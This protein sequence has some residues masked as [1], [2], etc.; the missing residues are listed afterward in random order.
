MS[1]FDLRFLD[2]P[3]GIFTPFLS[4][5]TLKLT[6]L[7]KSS[8][9]YTISPLEKHLSLSCSLQSEHFKHLE[10]HDR[11]NTFNI[12]RSN[13]GSPH[14]AHLGIAAEE[15]RRNKQLLH[16]YNKSCN[17]LY[18]YIMFG[19]GICEKYQS[20]DETFPEPNGERNLVSRL[21]FFANTPPK[22]D[23]AV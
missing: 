14:P 2:Q 5:M 15:K 23:I 7:K 22:H 13:I 12:K 8:L 4:E 11:S 16:F 21:V 10:C 19:R 20:R 18:I 3:F 1:F 6:Y 9:Q 17:I